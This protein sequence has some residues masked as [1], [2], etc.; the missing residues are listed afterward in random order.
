MR[1]KDKVAVV[2]GAGRGIGRATA[3]QLADEGAA[4]AV[5]ART[6]DE[7]QAVATE[8]REQ[9]AGANGG[10]ERLALAIPCDVTDEEQVEGMVARVL[11]EFGRIDL[12][13][14]NAGYNARAV[15]EET[16]AAAWQQILAVNTTGTFLC[17]RAVIGT[18]R[19]QGGGKIVNV[20]S[21]AGK[22]GSPTRGAYSAAK[23]GVI[24]FSQALQ[25]EVRDAGITVSC[26]SPGPVA[27]RLRAQNVPDEDMTA[28]LLPEDIA[29][30][31]VFVATR[32][33]RVVIPEFEVR[34]RAFL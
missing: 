25:A 26:V 20:V 24:G 8:I 17:S 1:L 15:V 32:P 21:G 2:T 11:E 27:T 19:R 31:I 34:P 29:E 7:I 28:L 14:N 4:V 22:R 9:R 6:A 10:G 16:T 23:F 3:L 18:M 5:I 13:V 33:E 12:L 30:A